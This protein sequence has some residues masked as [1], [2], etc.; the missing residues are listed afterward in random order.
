MEVGCC[1]GWVVC[2]VAVPSGSAAACCGFMVSGA[3]PVLNCGCVSSFAASSASLK[4][5]INIPIAFLDLFSSFFFYLVCVCNVVSDVSTVSV[6]PS[7]KLRLPNLTPIE[8][9]DAPVLGNTTGTSCFKRRLLV[10]DLRVAVV[11]S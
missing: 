2:A 1:C 3:T 5:P 7:F 4:N 11:E 10:E 6:V 9:R 8:L